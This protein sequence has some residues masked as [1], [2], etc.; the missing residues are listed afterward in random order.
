MK[1]III[2]L[3]ISFTIFI[4]IVFVILYNI[5]YP[6][7][8]SILFVPRINEKLYITSKIHG[9]AG[10]SGKLMIISTE[11]NYKQDSSVEYIFYGNLSDVYYY[12]ISKGTITIYTDADYTIP[13]SFKSKA[14]IKI[15]EL[16]Y[17]RFDS[18]S[19][20]YKEKGLKLL[21]I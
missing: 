4:A 6:V 3:L 2:I 15:V 11:P 16:S 1:K 21:P 17:D 14:K 12:S 5:I 18:L 13:K 8:T 20:N 9:Y 10:E 19:K 7:K